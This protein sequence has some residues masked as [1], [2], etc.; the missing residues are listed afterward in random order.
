MMGHPLTGLFYSVQFERD[1][2]E[3][4]DWIVDDLV[5]GGRLGDTAEEL[6]AAIDATLASGVSLTELDMSRA[7]RLDE[8]T[9]RS[10]LL[11]LR[12]R[13]RAAEPSGSS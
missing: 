12:S 8:E 1:P 7:R 2:H 9:L 3:A 6:A 13:L 11:A 10:F 4:I 5:P